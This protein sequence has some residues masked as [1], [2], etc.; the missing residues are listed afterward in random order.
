LSAANRVL[1]Q[2]DEAARSGD[3]AQFLITARAALQMAAR[4]QAAAGKVTTTEAPQLGSES[5]DIRQL[6]ALADE[7]HYSGH[8][9]TAIDFA[10]W[11]QVVRRR[12]LGGHA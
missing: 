11:T 9:P 7:S 5:E 1:V 12:M 6:S 3:T 4:W 2:L 8:E 10:R